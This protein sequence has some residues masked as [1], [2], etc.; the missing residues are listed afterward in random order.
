MIGRE[1][2]KVSLAFPSTRAKGFPRRRRLKA[3][4]EGK[5]KEKPSAFFH[6]LATRRVR[7]AHSPVS[8]LRQ[9]RALERPLSVD[10][11]RKQEQA[12]FKERQRAAF[13]FDS[14][15]DKKKKDAHRFRL[16][17]FS[18]LRTSTTKP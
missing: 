10:G 5:E 8:L 18:A 15:R 14:I 13:G 11:L 1:N 4:F 12:Q 9:L 6:S 7:L 16:F 3:T 2:K 17:F